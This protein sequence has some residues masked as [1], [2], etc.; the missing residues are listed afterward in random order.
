MNGEVSINKNT[1]IIFGIVDELNKI[2]TE[3]Q[4]QKQPLFLSVNEKFLLSLITKIINNP[5]KT[6]LIGITGESASGK[7]TLVENAAKALCEEGKRDLFTTVCCDDYYYDKSKDLEEAGSYENLF[8]TGFSFDTPKAVN[9]DLMKEHLLELKQGKNIKSPE[10][11]FVTCASELNK[12]EKKAS[13][14]VLNEGLYVLNP[15]II[16]VHD[17][18]VYVFTPFSIIRQRWYTRAAVRGKTGVAADMQF[19]DVNTAAQVYIRPTMQHADIVINGLT[20]TEYIEEVTL[21]ILRA[22]KKVLASV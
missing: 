3:D 10:Y 1:K 14:I 20:T 17:V 11:N 5:A 12:N 4:A 13:L 8:A 22:V 18:K 19:E 16:D 7:T 9:L 2:L 15:D 6:Y 21:K